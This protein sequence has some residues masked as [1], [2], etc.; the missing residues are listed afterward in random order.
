MHHGEALRRL[1]RR[2][3]IVT[4]LKEKEIPDFLSER[5]KSIVGYALKLTRTPAEM[6]KKDVETLRKNGLDDESIL[7]LAL[8]T[9]YFAF[10]NRL[11][12]GLGIDVEEYWG[13]ESRGDNS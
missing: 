11:A 1:S 3:D 9:G 12:D 6:E 4:E 8:V 5:E 10:V 2:D 13:G 7:N